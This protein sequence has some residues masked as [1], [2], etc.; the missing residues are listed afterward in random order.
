MQNC[1]Q[2]PRPS[3]SQQTLFLT[4][5]LQEFDQTPAMAKT[6]SLSLIS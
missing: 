5:E 4:N 3:G 6:T 1:E 2:I